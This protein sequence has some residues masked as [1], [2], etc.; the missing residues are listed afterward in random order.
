MNTNHARHARA[1]LALI[2]L[3]LAVFI[4]LLLVIDA[5]KYG[6]NISFYLGGMALWE[7]V[8]GFVF[9]VALFVWNAVTYSRPRYA[10]RSR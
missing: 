7:V 9:A 3:G 1:V 5:V 8:G 6:E 2:S 4:G 10:R